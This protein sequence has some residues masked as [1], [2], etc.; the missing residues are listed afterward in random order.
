[1]AKVFLGCWAD[2]GKIPDL[3]ELVKADAAAV[4]LRDAVKL[5][6]EVAPRPIALAL[7]KIIM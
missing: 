1:M 2:D 3:R 6:L 5:C 4:T 7:E